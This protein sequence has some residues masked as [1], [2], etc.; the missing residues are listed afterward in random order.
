VRSAVLARRGQHAAADEAARTGIVVLE[1]GGL[2]APATRS[3]L[4][5]AL[6]RRARGDAPG[7]DELFRETIEQ[8][9]GHGCEYALEEARQSWTSWKS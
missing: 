5:W 9:A 6:Q 7:A 1:R 2:H 8:L 4:A 3:R